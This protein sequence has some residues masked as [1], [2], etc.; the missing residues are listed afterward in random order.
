[1]LAWSGTAFSAAA[2]F[3]GGLFKGIIEKLGLVWLGK[4]LE[5]GKQERRAARVKDKQLEIAAEK[6]ASRSDILKRMRDDKL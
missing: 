2:S 5:R 1:M 4:K 3:I 6:P